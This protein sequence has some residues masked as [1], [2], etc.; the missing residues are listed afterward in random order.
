MDG[1]LARNRFVTPSKKDHKN[2]TFI[3][4]CYNPQ[5]LKVSGKIFDLRGRKIADMKV[6]DRVPSD[7]YTDIEWDPDQSDFGKAPSGLYV[8]QVIMGQKVYKGIVIVVR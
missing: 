8:Y 3:F 7:Y 4:S 2:D 1:S 5:D 6:N